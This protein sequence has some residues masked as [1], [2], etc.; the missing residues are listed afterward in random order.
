M[1]CFRIRL[2]DVCPTMICT[3]APAPTRSLCPAP[4]GVFGSKP[5]VSQA[6]TNLQLLDSLRHLEPGLLPSPLVLLSVGCRRYEEPLRIPTRLHPLDGARRASPRGIS[7][8]AQAYTRVAAR[9]LADPPTVGLCPSFVQAVTLLIVIV[10]TGMSRQL[11]RQ[12]LHL[13]DTQRLFT[14]H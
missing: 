13:P 1:R 6:L 4:S 7:R 8:P 11:P 2:S 9:R 10:A 12:T 3:D 5:G 14:A